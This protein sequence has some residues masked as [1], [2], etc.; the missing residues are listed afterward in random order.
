MFM[1]AADAEDKQIET[2]SGD[3]SRRWTGTLEK[4]NARWRMLGAILDRALCHPQLLLIGS[5]KPTPQ[6]RNK[7]MNN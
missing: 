3:T 5:M 2:F 7:N 4:D 6:I 1:D